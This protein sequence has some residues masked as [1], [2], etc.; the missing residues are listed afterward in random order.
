MTWCSSASAMRASRSASPAPRPSDFGLD[1]DGADFGEVRAVEMER[2][3]AEELVFAVGVV[4]R[5]GDGEVADVFADLGVGA[6][7][8]R[9]VAGEGVDE[10]EDVAGVLEAGL[11]DADVGVAS[12]VRRPPAVARVSR[13]SEIVRDAVLRVRRGLRRRGCVAVPPMTSWQSS[14]A[15]R[16]MASKKSSAKC[17]AELSG[18]RRAEAALSSRLCRGRGGRR[19]R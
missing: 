14:V 2:A 11:V 10:V 6:A 19:C 7:E 15:A 3:A 9:A 17:G 18:G 1:D 8:E 13:M 12:H 5:Y 4:A 16:V